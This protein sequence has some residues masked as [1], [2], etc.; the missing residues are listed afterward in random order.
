MAEQTS[1]V[2]WE[3]E[4]REVNMKKCLYCGRDNAD[5]ALN[6]Y[7]CGTEFEREAKEVGTASSQLQEEEKTLIIRLFSNY[8][9][10]GLAV[11]KLEAHGIK[12][13]V[14]TD[15]CGGW[16]TNLTAAAGV[17]LR[18]RAEDTEV[19]VALLDAKPTDEEIK[20]IEVEAV[21]A[22]P[23]KSA[24]PGKLAWG[25]ISIGIFF[26]IIICLLYQWKVEPSRTTHYHYNADGKRDGE[27]IYRNGHLVEILEDRNL[28]GAWDR[29]YFYEHGRVVR[30]EMDNNFDGKA[31]EFW[32]FSD[33]GG[34]TLQRD[35]DFNGIPD[36][37]ATYKYEIIQQ[38]EIRPNGSKFATVREKYR[39]GVL[40]EIWRG[41]DS[42]G[43]FSEVVRYDPFFNP[44]S[45]NAPS[46]APLHTP[47]AK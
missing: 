39:N 16:Y 27:W 2:F 18:V 6:C 20:K 41:G 45:T 14:D 29:W 24:P 7:E 11:A 22:T 34:A 38:E 33:D 5:E 47:A 15:D 9:E 13:W 36:E 19:A 30:S 3:R 42:N 46:S 4:L 35:T 25:Q 26:G 1:P 21:L 44:I 32:T 23:P 10:A 31:D 17:R 12:S 8:D 40:T 28:D 37:F 43:K